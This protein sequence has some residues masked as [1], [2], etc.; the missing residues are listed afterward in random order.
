ML[1]N[2][3]VLILIFAV[4]VVLWFLLIKLFKC[5]NKIKLKATVQNQPSLFYVNWINCEELHLK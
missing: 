2:T 5:V 4:M 3:L 1:S